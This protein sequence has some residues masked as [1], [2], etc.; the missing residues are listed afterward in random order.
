MFGARRPFFLAAALIGA[1]V[2]P[3]GAQDGDELPAFAAPMLDASKL[4]ES[5]PAG[6]VGALLLEHLQLVAAP[7]KALPMVLTVEVQSRAGESLTKIRGPVLDLA[8]LVGGPIV[9][10]TDEY[11]DLPV[12][13]MLPGGPEA[14][15]IAQRFQA[16]SLFAPETALN[17]SVG[18]TSVN[19]TTEEVDQEDIRWPFDAGDD[20]KLL[21]IHIVPDFSLP[22]N[23]RMPEVGGGFSASAITLVIYL[24][25]AAS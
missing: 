10:R 1:M 3:L 7:G 15:G 14:T 20:A 19:P 23:V 13:A 12:A 2:S 4:P 8:A 22:P 24:W 6:T 25:P 5:F 17:A 9:P 21:L 18:R 11:L 16:L